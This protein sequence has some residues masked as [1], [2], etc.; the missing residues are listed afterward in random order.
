MSEVEPA[1]PYGFL[2]WFDTGSAWRF[3]P[4]IDSELQGASGTIESRSFGI[5]WRART[6]AN[7]QPLVRDETVLVHWGWIAN[8][9]ELA[10]QLGPEVR[11]ARDAELL[12]ASYAYWGS[13]FPKQVKGKLSFVLFDRRYGTVLAGRDALG[14]KKI[15]V[16]RTG[17]RT[18]LASHLEV[19]LAALPE[20]PKLD[21]MQVGRTIRFG[22]FND[23]LSA[24][25]F[26]GISQL[27]P[28][29]TASFCA[30][31]HEPRLERYW[32]PGHLAEEPV[33]EEQFR[34]TLFRNVTAALNER[35]RILAELSG[36][37]DS[38]SVAAIAALSLRDCGR[39][40]DLITISYIDERHELDERRFQRDL[41]S[42]H[43]LA[44]EVFE[45]DPVLR[46]SD[47][48][49]QATVGIHS[50]QR[51]LPADQERL[52][53]LGADICLT[54]QGGDG[55][56]GNF[57][58]PASWPTCSGADDGDVG[59]KR[60][61]CSPMADW[62]AGCRCFVSLFEDASRGRVSIRVG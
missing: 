31:G 32:S 27:L 34:E 8:R 21:A 49:D 4:P 39:A 56:L 44:N 46:L 30:E 41:C 11:G 29:H 62:G 60:C 40:E 37:L 54:G 5:R 7:A 6:N 59:G 61:V 18:W 42:L 9:A 36:G 3:Q 55:V 43:G 52:N 14:L 28:A 53:A 25:V 2:A 26:R 1:G 35:G 12:L 47:F 45:L 48:R 15:F 23:D 51:L 20:R 17:H 10:D 50:F 57:P 33:D 19:M 13:S 22:F 58:S 16:H 38:S 24:M